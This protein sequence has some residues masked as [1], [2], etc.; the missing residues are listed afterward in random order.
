MTF[1]LEAV[2]E[3]VRAFISAVKEG[4]ATAA[5]AAQDSSSRKKQRECLSSATYP[6][7]NQRAQLMIISIRYHFCP[8]RDHAGSQ[9]RAERCLVINAWH[10]SIS[11]AAYRRCAADRKLATDKMR[12]SEMRPNLAS[13]AKDWLRAAE[14]AQGKEYK[15]AEYKFGYQTRVR[16]VMVTDHTEG[17]QRGWAGGRSLSSI[18]DVPISLGVAYTLLMTSKSALPQ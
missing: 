6:H 1:P 17:H 3:N 4:S 15:G 18:P 7:G 8:H 2:E 14:Y 10:D 9:Y 13:Q 5:A 11:L 12:V 16:P